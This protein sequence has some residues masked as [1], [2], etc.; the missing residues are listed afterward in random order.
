MSRR[1]GALAAVAL[2][3]YAALWLGFVEGWGPITALDDG[4]LR[5]FHEFGATRPGWITF[6]NGVSAVFGPTG[7]RVIAALGIVAAA[8]RR[9]FR[10]VG[11]LAVTVMLM[12][13]LTAV[14]KAISDRPRPDT[15]LAFASS[16]SFPSGHALGA[17]VGVLTFATLLW[18]GIA[19]WAKTTVIVLGALIV[20]AVGLSRVA[21]NVHHPTDVIAGW[22]LGYLWY[23]LCLMLIPP[24]SHSGSAAPQRVSRLSGH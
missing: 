24:R 6:W 8:V 23:R 19:S 1:S 3:I 7:M 5:L 2:V 17:M 18:P 21:L 15:A 4:I 20:L 16:T 22:A 9:Q 14:A 12:G 13:P 11:F 10:T